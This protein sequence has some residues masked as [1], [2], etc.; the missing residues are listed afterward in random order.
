MKNGGG[1]MMKNG[2]TGIHLLMNMALILYKRNHM[3]TSNKSIKATV[4]GIATV[5]SIILVC[6]FSMTACSPGTEDEYPVRERQ[7]GMVLVDSNQVV[8]VVNGKDIKAGIIQEI[9]ESRVLQEQMELG[10]PL[11][12]RE[13]DQK[14]RM[15]IEQLII[16]EVIKQAVEASTITV[17]Q[18]EIDRRI[19]VIAEEF[20]GMVNFTN[21]LVTRG[22]TLDAFKEDARIDAIAAAMMEAQIGAETTTVD[23]AKE[24]YEEH[25]PE[26]IFPEEVTVSHILMQVDPETPADMQSN[27]VKKLKDI[28]QEILDGLEFGEAAAIYSECPSAEAKGYIGTITRNDTDISKPFADG[29]FATPLSNVSDIVQTEFGSHLIYVTGK[30]GVRTANFELVKFAVM[31]YLDQVRQREMIRDWTQ[32]LRAK[33]NVIYKKNF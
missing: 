2:I 32:K 23:M 27:I 21:Y 30:E 3:T 22:Y 25:R 13:I 29:A 5:I 15:L 33:A 18:A 1:P 11:A 9:L 26:F 10:R 28:K 24:Y 31:N 14:R 17:S 20:G 19:D 7:A 12:Q 8:A 4:A 16:E 6:F